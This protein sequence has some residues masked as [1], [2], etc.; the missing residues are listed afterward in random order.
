M[1]PGSLLGGLRVKPTD[2][3]TEERRR[4]TMRLL[5]RTGVLAISATSIFAQQDGRLRAGE[6]PPR[7]LR[8]DVHGFADPKPLR[9]F[10][11]LCEKA[12]AIVYGVVETDASRMMQGQGTRIET[13]FWIK[14]EGVL[15]GAVDTPKIVVSEMG[16]TFGEARLIMNFPLLQRGEW[17]VLFLFADKRPGI[18]P[19]EN[20]PRYEAEIFYGT[21]RVDSGRISPVFGNPF[22]GKY[23]GLPLDAFTA[24]IAGALRR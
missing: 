17:Y 14:V 2:A 20:L 22:E 24:E 11:S 8:G 5:M 7:L 15:K 10:K 12:D 3:D 6:E 18:P 9:S 16:G 13:D 23:N 1:R 19:I 4:L 21:F